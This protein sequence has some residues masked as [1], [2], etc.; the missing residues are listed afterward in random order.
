VLVVGD[1]NV[2]SDRS[3][4]WPQLAEAGLVQAPGLAGELGSTLKSGKRYDRI[5]CTTD[6]AGRLSGRAGTVDWFAG[7]WDEILP[8]TGMTEARLTWEVSD[9]LPVW[10]E[11][12]TR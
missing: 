5:L 9:H 11:V 7:G 1:F 6:D 12:G 10:A 2:A 3:R 4:V 8:G